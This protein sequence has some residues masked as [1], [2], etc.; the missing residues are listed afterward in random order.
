MQF[1]LFEQ[2]LETDPF[3]SFGD[4]ISARLS[5]SSR[6]PRYYQEE[7]DAAIVR[8]HVDYES[9]LVV[10]ATGLGKSVLV[11][12]RARRTQ[13]N[14][15][16]MA[17]RDELV[18]QMAEHLELTTGESVEIEQADLRA[19]SKARIVVASTQSLSQARLD[20]LGK[21]RFELVVADEFHHYL[22]PTYRRAWEFFRGKKLGVTATPDRTDEKALAQICDVVAY[23]FDIQDGIDAGY[24][25]PIVGQQVALED[26]DISTVKTA[27]G[28]LV[29]AQLDEIMLK[30]ADGL[31][32]E[33]LRIAPT[34]SG[35]IFMPGVKSAEYVAKRLNHLRAG[36]AGFVSG[37]DAWSPLWDPTTV[38][39]KTDRRRR[40]VAE[41]KSG[42]LQWLANC[43]VLTEGF[44]WPSATMVG[45]GRPTKSRSLFAQMAGRGTRVLPGVVDHIP[46]KE[47][48][49]ARRAAIAISGKPELLLLDFQGNA[50]RHTLVGPEDLLG[51]NF[52]EAEVE[53]AKKEA[54]SGGASD[55]RAALEAAR[56]TLKEL[57][58]RKA[59]S[60]KATVRS[61]D[62][63]AAVGL[64]IE[65]ES[66]YERRFGHKQLSTKQFELLTK[67][68]VPEAEAQSLSRR[69]ASKLIDELFARQEKGLATL[70]QL[71]A[72]APFGV[73][74][75]KATF[76]G[77]SEALGFAWGRQRRGHGVNP[78][79]L[80][81]M[82]KR[83]R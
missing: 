53:E 71:K 33:L 50:G 72:L 27:A 38:P 76:Q 21:N 80:L 22:A 60:V 48:A 8:A 65:E 83:G 14:V 7:G 44:D 61:F 69:E 54:K 11:A 16:V 25:V 37:E 15:L 49:A 31:V 10:M 5:P 68:G 42:K 26:V 51:G 43:Q 77:A 2:S 9:C 56:R 4:N 34:S 28:D 30:A 23:C 24:L 74:D 13:G 66:R 62:P 29:A 70:K 1:G 67:K 78:A 75:P 40:V 41:A 18:S 36:S 82:V 35:P 63:F 47:G 17:H 46:G 58:A 81:E 73:N 32:A 52:T 57:A 55:I 64:D 45:L 20:R 6:T 3:D 39:D 79:Q 59:S 12:E 19:S